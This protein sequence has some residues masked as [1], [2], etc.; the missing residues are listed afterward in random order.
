M[1]VFCSYSDIYY[2]PKLI[3]LLE[4]L[5][6][7]ALSAKF[8]VLALDSETENFLIAEGRKNLKILTLRE[9]EVVFPELAATKG[10]RSGVEYIF[11]LTPYMFKYSNRISAPNEMVVY[12]DA[13]LF[14][15]GRVSTVLDVLAGNH[16]GIIPHL[17]SRRQGHLRKFG[18]FNVGLVAI[19]NSSYGRECSDWWSERCIEWCKDQPIDGK[20]ADQGYL[21]RFPSLFTGVKIL[22]SR[23][24]NLA[25]WN[26]HG[27]KISQ[28]SQGRVLVGTDT[29]L[30]FFHFHGLRRL[31]KWMITS[32]LNYRS[33]ASKELID[34]VYKPYLV[35][36]DKVEKVVAQRR[37]ATVAPMLARGR[38]LRKF[39][40]NLTNR[41]LMGASIVTGN[42][43]DMSRLK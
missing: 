14:F 4:S 27:Q 35:S 6:D 7:E 10:S 31:G 40:R 43:I 32:Q 9:M 17:Y 24:F 23:G 13:D 42:A 20:Y 8:V 25:P 21:D 5:G 15:F 12:L 30:I 29:P 28:D 33:P 36:L 2:L 26:T 18:T 37:V 38:G 16:I 19:R 1:T 3:S 11:T 22:E 41:I 34:L 39:A